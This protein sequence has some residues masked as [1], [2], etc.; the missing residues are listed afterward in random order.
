MGDVTD[1]YSALNWGYGVVEHPRSAGEHA[2]WAV[3]GV[4]ADFVGLMQPL[5]EQGAKKFGNA[6][7]ASAAATPIIQAGLLAMMGMS[8]ACG[9]GEPEKGDRFARGSEAF[10]GVGDELGST[11]SPQSWQGDASDAYADRNH[12]QQ[13]RAATLAEIDKTVKGVL[14]NEAE[15]VDV[16]RKM[17]DRCQTVLGL[18]IPA[19][20]VAKAIVPG[21]PAISLGIEIA[22]VGA[23]LPLATARFGE[24]VSNAAHNATLIRR[25]GASYDEITSAAGSS[26]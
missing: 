18:S 26:L 13:R 10:D 25:A 24:L 23:T 22:A 5:A 17:L 9:F 4:G 2:G 21:G 7:V 12:E 19:A 16:A 8:N 14:D 11:T 6:R 20:I 15:Q 1:V 3:A